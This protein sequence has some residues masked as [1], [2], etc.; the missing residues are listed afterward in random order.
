MRITQLF[1]YGFWIY[2]MFML[3]TCTGHC[4]QGRI[5]LAYAVADAGIQ[6]NV[7]RQK[8]YVEDQYLDLESYANI[9]FPSYRGHTM[10]RLQPLMAAY[11]SYHLYL[12]S[13]RTALLNTVGLSPDLPLAMQPLKG[14]HHL[15][16]K[17]LLSGQRS[18]LMQIAERS[19]SL[20]AAMLTFDDHDKM[21]EIMLPLDLSVKPDGSF[22]L[23][24]HTCNFHDIPLSGVL[25][26]L[27]SLQA[28]A[29]GSMVCVM[30]YCEQQMR[31]RGI[32]C[33]FGGIYPSISAKS[34]YILSGDTY[35]SDIF[36]AA[37]SDKIRNEETW[38]NGKL[39][40]AKDGIAL[41]EARSNKVGPHKFQVNIRGNIVL[42]HFGRYY[43]DTFEVSKEFA[44]QVVSPHPQISRP[45]LA[46]YL[47]ANT[48]NPITITAWDD[49]SADTVRVSSKNAALKHLGGGRYTLTPNSNNPVILSVGKFATFK[50]EVRPLPDPVP[51]FGNYV[52]GQ[53]VQHGLISAQTALNAR[54]PPDFDFQV[55][56][57]I[58]NFHLTRFRGRKD[59]E[60]VENQ[61]EPFNASVR[62]LLKTAQ[63][64]DRLLFDEIR[65]KCGEEPSPR[66]LAGLSLRV[67]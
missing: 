54:F 2:F 5:I 46:N 15:V 3:W 6:S 16:K 29:S 64:G 42:E 48:E 30:Y 51:V 36:I 25:S 17:F 24:R 62:E 39:I 10:E 56:C 52:S 21:V 53:A 45:V 18:V 12:D 40:P 22:T 44:Y 55:D 27:S 43:L 1:Q 20:R 14:N 7:V 4:D 38:I 57:K 63:P 66:T 32:I 50:Y 59:P 23:F 9:A 67:E 35:Q 41:Y 58:L 37:Y 65:V 11:R 31:Y 34:T 13:I 60:V 61:G 49:Y 33:N 28:S 8:Q 19:Y 47:Y 26:M